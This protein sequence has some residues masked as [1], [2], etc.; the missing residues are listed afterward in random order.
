[1]QARSF[2]GYNVTSLIAFS[3]SVGLIRFDGYYYGGGNE[4]LQIHDLAALP[5]AGAVPLKSFALPQGPMF[6]SSMGGG[7]A[8]IRVLNGL[9]FVISSTDGT[10]TAS[11]STF[12]IVGEVEEWETSNTQLGLL[13][14]TEAG[15]N[16][17]QVW[18]QA[19]GPH[20][21]Y[22]IDFTGIINRPLLTPR[23][24]LLCTDDAMATIVEAIPLQTMEDNTPLIYLNSGSGKIKFGL[25]GHSPV[26]RLTGTAGP[27]AN[28][29]IPAYPAQGGGLT[30]LSIA[31]SSLPT[32]R[33]QPPTETLTL[34]AYYL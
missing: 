4:Y 24:L 13:S 27:N 18:A 25:S 3:Q 9:V 6:T 31:Y 16:Y 22:E 34:T 30:G 28:N 10:Y 5:I 23:W 33:V 12:D 15:Q 26:F 19:A 21:L 7:L 8:P 1:M 2:N 20:V 29:I 17:L 32:A 11:A 14:T